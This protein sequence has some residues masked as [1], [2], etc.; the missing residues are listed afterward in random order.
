MT[1]LV[2]AVLLATVVSC[3]SPS[4]AAWPVRPPALPAPT[5][6]VVRVS[7]ETG[8]QA[9][10]AALHSHETILIAPGTYRLSHTLAVQGPLEDVV[11]RGAT[12]DRDDVVLAGYGRD[13]ADYG[14]V[15]H[16]I[17]VSGD[18]RRLTIAN[19]TIGETYFHAICFNPGPTSPRVYNVHLVNA[20]QQLLKTNPNPDGSGI[21]NGVIEYS[22]FEYAPESRDWYANAIQV[23]AGRNWVIRDN[24]IQNIRAPRGALAGPAVLAW[25]GASGTVVE[26]NTFVNCQREIA[27]GLVVRAPHDHAGGIIRNNV[28]YRDKTTA[29]G[30]V[31][32]GVFD[33]PGS[34]V[35]N[36]SILMSG[37][38]PNAI[39][40]RFPGTSG[41]RVVNNLSNRRVTLRDGA[42]ATLVTNVDAARQEWFVDPRTTER[43]AQPDV[44]AV[45]GRGTALPEVTDDWDGNPRPVRRAPDVGAGQAVEL[46]PSK[47]PWDL[48]G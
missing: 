20:G 14:P 16:G 43:H 2:A 38:Y 31:A 48:I 13:N 21:D 8:L 1:R 46:A 28:I 44:N 6:K 26:R 19:L 36:N 45:V 17:W 27:F 15:P 42:A 35:A 40:C 12:N 34:V 39:E 32:I 22:L 5:G 41:V 4:S 3:P 10:I 23:L 25:F 47:H 9:A 18:V 37:S 30:D 24:F 7:T 33:S 29:G 11:I